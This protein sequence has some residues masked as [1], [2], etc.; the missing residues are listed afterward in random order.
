MGIALITAMLIA[1][2]VT[3][4]AVALAASQQFNTRRTANL[5]L[6]DRADLGIREIEGAAG[7]T[8][9][10]DAK[11]AQYDAG[12][13]AWAHTK[14]SAAR[15]DLSFAAGLSDLQGRFNLTNL[16]P[17]PRVGGEAG[18]PPTA[19]SKANGPASSDQDSGSPESDSA[20]TAAPVAT[21]L[22]PAPCASGTPCRPVDT[23]NASPLAL[24]KTA[25]TDASPTT[26]ASVLTPAQ[27]AEQQFRLLFKA[28]ELDPEPIQAI[29]DWIDPDTE[30]R[31]PNGAEDDYYTN[32]APAY[33]TAN[34]PFVSPRELLLVKGVTM[35][36]YKKL[37]PFIVTLPQSTKINVNTAS[38]E[39]LMSLAPGIDASVAE[40]LIRARETQPFLSV[41]SFLKHPLLQF[42]EVPPDLIAVDTH[43][44]ELTS[45]AS[46]E[47]LDYRMRSV[48]MRNGATVTTVARQRAELDE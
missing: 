11:R 29:L 7:Q 18:V 22:P 42:R 8:L 30:T 23:G 27:L 6:A 45:T 39:V 28:L 9:I 5:L 38:K 21:A 31:F 16:S 37:A 20:T 12:T 13:E 41:E 3:A 2:L 44:F 48:L 36:M 26:N 47:R 43:Y 25:A 35:E 10:A 17:D 40:Q 19:A 1:A 15:A 4:G 14:F 32:Q 24:S 33:R 46:N 34:R